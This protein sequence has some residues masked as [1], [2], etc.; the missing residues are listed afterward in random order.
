VVLEHLDPVPRELI[1]RDALLGQISL[2][3]PTRYAG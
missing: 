2:R 1:A 3:D